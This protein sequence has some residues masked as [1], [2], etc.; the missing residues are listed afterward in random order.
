MCEIKGVS[1]PAS[2]NESSRR[3]DRDFCQ[4]RRD[5]AVHRR[6]CWSEESTDPSDLK[7]TGQLVSLIT[8]KSHQHSTHQ[9]I[10]SDKGGGF[11]TLMAAVERFVF[12][13]SVPRRLH[14]VEVA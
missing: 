11:E 13:N 1:L 9:L 12:G 7:H 5:W 14:S 10:N 4:I 8:T 2:E 3:K 6:F